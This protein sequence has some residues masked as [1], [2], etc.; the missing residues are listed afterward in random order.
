MKE[1]KKPEKIFD[2]V[3]DRLDFDWKQVYELIKEPKVDKKYKIEFGKFDF[4]KVKKILMKY[5]FSEQRIEK[6]FDKLRQASDKRKQ[7]TLF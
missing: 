2:S 7:K 4:D 1:Y 5:E 3:A 6:Q